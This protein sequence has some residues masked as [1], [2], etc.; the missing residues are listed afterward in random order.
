MQSLLNYH[1]QSLE[2]LG[3]RSRWE[4]ICRSGCGSML[5]PRK[6][7]SFWYIQTALNC[8]TAVLCHLTW[9]K[10]SVGCSVMIHVVLVLF[11]LITPWVQTQ[12]RVTEYQNRNEQTKASSPIQH[13]IFCIQITFLFGAPVPISMLILY[14]LNLYQCS[15]ILTMDAAVTWFKKMQLDWVV[16][17]KWRV[18]QSSPT[19]EGAK[20][21]KII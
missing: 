15:Y 8:T 14:W 1:C 5:S 16:L 11:T 10:S 13:E 3:L 20:E 21:F 9:E 17:E 7:Q 6:G 19:L 2:V 18:N 12:E 4:I